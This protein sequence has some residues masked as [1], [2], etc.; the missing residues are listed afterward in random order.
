MKIVADYYNGIST[1][2]RQQQQQR[3]TTTSSAS[4]ASSARHTAAAGMTAPGVSAAA[5]GRPRA[6]ARPNRRN[7]GGAIDYVEGPTPPPCGAA[8]ASTCSASA[9]AATANAD[10]DLPWLK[11]FEH[12]KEA[13]RTTAEIR[14]D[15]QSLTTIREELGD[16]AERIIAML[17]TFDSL[18]A[19][20]RVM[21]VRVATPHTVDRE[22]FALAFAQ[23]RA[24]LDLKLPFPPP[25]YGSLR[26]IDVFFIIYQ[27]LERTT[28]G[29]HKSQYPHAVQHKAT[30]QMLE[31]GDL[32]C[33]SLSALKSCHAEVGRVA[34]KTGCKRIEADRE[35]EVT[36]S[37]KPLRPHNLNGTMGPTRLTETHAITTMA[38]SV[39]CRL[40]AAKALSKD[41]GKCIEMRSLKRI[42]LAPEK[43]GGR[44][45]VRRTAPKL[46]APDVEGATCISDARPHCPATWAFT[47]ARLHIAD[48]DR[49][50]SMYR[51]YAL[52][53]NYVTHMLQTAA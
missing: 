21:R 8:A 30:A 50:I 44:S 24:L 20:R 29:L 41:E 47:V 2:Q 22:R 31:L 43:G 6:G 26:K 5:G 40:V 3:A 36:R 13:A 38:S 49:S 12:A 25:S 48:T 32:W 33:L 28:L 16:R 39:S 15:Q 19:F 52:Q 35:G 7:R 37:S 11:A 9:T 23:S 18:F 14:A 45:T 17:L 34:D 4:S 51:A 10:T 53:L 1:A 27:H 46:N 42:A